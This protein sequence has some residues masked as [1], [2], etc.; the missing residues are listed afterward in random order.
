[1]CVKKIITHRFHKLK[2]RCVGLLVPVELLNFEFAPKDTVTKIN[3]Y[4]KSKRWSGLP[5]RHSELL[6]I[7]SSHRFGLLLRW[8]IW[9]N[10]VR[11]SGLGSVALLALRRLSGSLRAPSQPTRHTGFRQIWQLRGPNLL[12]WLNHE[13]WYGSSSC[14]VMILLFEWLSRKK[15]TSCGMTLVDDF[16][17][18]DPLTLPVIPG[19][20]VYKSR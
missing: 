19:E 13:V 18:N 9:V 15:S 2:I 10:S 20:R 14:I 4:Q 11:L 17:R 6:I 7:Q 3:L 12:A 5:A 16:I 1:M 8:Q